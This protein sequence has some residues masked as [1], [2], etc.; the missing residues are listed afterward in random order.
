MLLN[1]GHSLVSDRVSSLLSVWQ[2]NASPPPPRR[3][4]SH[5]HR[6]ISMMWHNGADVA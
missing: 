1:S 5:V 6:R 2:Q 3:G 4:D